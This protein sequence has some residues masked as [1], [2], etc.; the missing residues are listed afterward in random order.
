MT[1]RPTPEAIAPGQESV[2]DYP[3]P[4]AVVASD[5]QIVIML[6]GVEICETT[7]S[8]RVLETGH[9][10]TYYLPRNAFRDG[11]LVPCAGRS[12]CEWKGEAS[13]LD[14]VGGTTVARKA[15]WY[16]RQPKDP[17]G[18][19]VGLVAIYPGR[20]DLCLVDGERVVPQEGG[21]YGGWI[22]STVVGPFK[23]APGTQGW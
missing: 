4:P 7:S 23:G 20:V 14:L 3:R 5:E 18:V 12:Y 16:Y 2:W 22:T 9:P 6:G 17:Y 11:A 8:W 10:P 15:G 13:Y 1:D 19:L 21:Y